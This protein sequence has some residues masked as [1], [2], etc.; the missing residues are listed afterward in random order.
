V[1]SGGMGFFKKLFQGRMNRRTYFVGNLLIWISL[2]GVLVLLRLTEVLL[3]FSSI[4][5]AAA[6][7]LWVGVQ[8]VYI[9]SFQ[10][11][12]GHDV[13][14]QLDFS[15]LFLGHLGI[16]MFKKGDTK[17]NQFGNSPKPQI[18]IKGMLGIV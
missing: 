4:F 13:G 10:V 15:D 1:N 17:R 12:R 7:L 6:L 5:Y 8:T 3:R 14:L 11:R 18:D 9:Y 2:F 16:I